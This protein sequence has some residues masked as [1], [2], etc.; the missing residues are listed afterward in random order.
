MRIHPNIDF[1]LHAECLF[2]KLNDLLKV[3]RIIRNSAGREVLFFSAAR[4]S[5]VLLPLAVFYDFFPFNY[6]TFS[7]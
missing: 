4:G 2:Q 3:G 5:G 1:F 7:L 6:S